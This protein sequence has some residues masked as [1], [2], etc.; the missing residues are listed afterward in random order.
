MRLFRRRLLDVLWVPADVPGVCP[1]PVFVP[2]ACSVCSAPRAALCR[3][4]GREQH[5]G[6]GSAGIFSQEIDETATDNAEE[7]GATGAHEDE[8]RL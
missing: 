6:V 5:S 4:H 8:L 1:G 2:P 7:E 3:G